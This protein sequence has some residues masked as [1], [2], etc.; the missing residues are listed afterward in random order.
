MPFDV[1]ISY[2]PQDK[3]TAEAV[4]ARLEASNVRCWIASRDINAGAD[5]VESIIEALQSCRV[6]ILIFSSHSNASPQV[7]YEVQ[8][9]FE[10][11]LTVMPFR[12]EDVQ[13]SASIKYYIGS[14][15]WLDALGE[16]M[17]RHIEKLIS[18]VK[19]FIAAP[20]R[21][22]AST[23]LP[24]GRVSPAIPEGIA[25]AY[26]AEPE[27]PDSEST[28]S[29]AY[30]PED[31]ATPGGQRNG[32]L[33]FVV[34]LLIAVL[35][36]A[37]AIA[38]W[39]FEVVQP[40]QLAEAKRQQ[41]EQDAA[42]ARVDAAKRQ[43]SKAAVASL[44]LSSSPS[45]LD[46]TLLD[47]TNLTIKSGMTP[48][49]IEGLPLDSY[50][51]VFKY[52]SVELTK[53]VELTEEGK[54]VSMQGDFQEMIKLIQQVKDDQGAISRGTRFKQ[55]YTNIIKD[56]ASMAYNSDGGPRN[57]KLKDLLARN[58]VT[59]NANTPLSKYE[60]T[61]SGAPTRQASPSPA[62][63]VEGDTDYAAWMSY[64]KSE[65]G[66]EEEAVKK[67]RDAETDVQKLVVDLLDVAKIDADA[68]AIVDR[69]GIKINPPPSEKD[70]K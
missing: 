29:A 61:S 62:P 46:F 9:A 23:T 31:R 52:S 12:I 13:P 4:C 44:D 70:A 10:K 54:T 57:E 67:A 45:G 37:G 48:S 14:V 28:P 24:A 20:S 55:V 63:P 35:V 36:I 22:Q 11:G 53:K 69:Y 34:A 30:Y 47:K 7:S 43:E 27:E 32:P 38:G 56:I 3:A 1:F 68:K 66:G 58:G 25:P 60:D 26:V 18:Q 16:P 39:W 15:H 49:L 41:Q 19:L 64:L 50:K 40:K 65:Q 17:E 21:E 59:V 8:A 33:V 5:R 2:S 6:M 42:N 51:V